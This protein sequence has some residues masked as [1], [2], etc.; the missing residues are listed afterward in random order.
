MDRTEAEGDS[1]WV[2]GKCGGEGGVEFAGGAKVLQQG[3]SLE[4]IGNN[5]IVKGADSAVILF[6]AATTFREEDPH[7]YCK[8][9]LEK[10]AGYS[11]DELAE[12]QLQDYSSLFSKMELDL[13]DAEDGR[14]LEFF[15]QYGRYLLIASSRPGSLPANLQGIWN[16]DMLPVWDSKYTININ[17]QMNYWPAETCNLSQC[18]EPLFDLIERMRE[19][20]RKTAEVMYGCKGFMAHHNT[21]IW[22]DT[23]P[24]D[25]CLSST[26]WVMGAAWLCLHLWEH[27]RFTLDVEFLRRIYPTM[28]EAMEFI[29]DFLTEDEKGRLVISPTLSPENEYRLPGGQVGVLCKGASMD[30][31]IIR[32]L[33]F[34][35][36]KAKEVLDEPEPF[37]GRMLE[38]ISCV[39]DIAVGKYGQIMEWAEDYE[40]VDPG[41]RHISHLFALHPGTQITGKKPDW[42]EAARKTLERRL[43]NGGGH[44]GWS[45]AWI[46]NMWA[47][48]GEGDKALA[49]IRALLNHSTLPNLFDDHPPF[50]IDGNFGCTAG[51][52]EMLLQSHEDVLRI[53]PALP[54]GWKT[55]KV[56]GLRARGGYT[57]DI[58]WEDG[59][60]V[61]TVITADLNDDKGASDRKLKVEI[62]GEIKEYAV[63]AGKHL[64]L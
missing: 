30:H 20:G 39:P 25:V 36:M 13:G 56:K 31:Q 29:L 7:A 61:Q 6:T 42:Q 58:T 55:G 46:V 28:L 3:G 12:R 38:K 52:A 22:A 4:I 11:Y 15:F 16:Q 14:L 50:Q 35:I 53:L 60:A 49:D 43:S 44:T 17:T 24:Q 21:D 37:A 62:N 51:V 48:L 19:N 27:Y 23:A 34:A 1:L 32:E 8:E 54:E 18:H 63:K 5:V 33:Y 59:K 45:R 57:V 47:R 2:S 9:T 64:Q 10:A 26:Y 40:E 41:H